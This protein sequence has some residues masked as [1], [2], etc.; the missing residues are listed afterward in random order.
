[1]GAFR[2]M[3]G[4]NWL[5]AFC[6][7][8]MSLACPR[9]LSSST[10]LLPNTLPTWSVGVPLVHGLLSHK[11]I[12]N[13]LLAYLAPLASRTAQM[14]IFVLQWMLLKPQPARITFCQ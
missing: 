11:C 6:L 2:L 10:L 14:A 12:G 7:K 3:K 9:A 13:W 8:S 4:C 5:A 1:M